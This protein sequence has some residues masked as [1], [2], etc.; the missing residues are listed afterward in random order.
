L[1]FPSILRAGTESEAD[2]YPARLRRY[3]P[4]Q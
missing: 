1:D 2:A 4:L 3:A